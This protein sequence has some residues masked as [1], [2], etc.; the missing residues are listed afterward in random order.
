MMSSR[1]PKKKIWSFFISS[2]FLS[3]SKPLDLEGN[4]EFKNVGFE[5]KE[6][7]PVLKD[8]NFKLDKGKS[9]AFVGA[10]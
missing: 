4:I 10:T 5:Y 7:V 6:N 1:F 2:F 9:I 3:F 8:V